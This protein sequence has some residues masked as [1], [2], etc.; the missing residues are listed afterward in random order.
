MAAV[1]NLLGRGDYTREEVNRMEESGLLEGPYELI[2]GHLVSKMGQNPPHA[3]A[4]RLVAIWLASIF[5]SHRVQWQLPVEVS[6]P[7]RERNDPLPDIGVLREFK[8]EYG[9]R[10]PVGDEFLLLVE[11]SDTSSRYDRTKKVPLY[12]RA[13]APEYWIVDLPKRRLIVYRNPQQGTYLDR[14]EFAEHDTIS[15]A[16]CQTT[17]TNLL[18]KSIS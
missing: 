2:D 10:H 16:N 3:Y 8:D 4:L 11:I 6:F 12:A 7:D 15:I 14:H 9:R 17:V 13:G 1:P 18:P 5:G